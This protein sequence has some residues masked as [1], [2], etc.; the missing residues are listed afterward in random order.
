MAQRRFLDLPNIEI[1]QIVLRKICLQDAEDLFECLSDPVLTERMMH[2]RVETLHAMR[3]R[4]CGYL[5]EYERHTNVRFGAVL[6]EKHKMIGSVM[7]MPIQT[8]EK[9]SMGF[10]IHRAYWGHGYA[11]DMVRAA[12][13]FAFAKAGFTEI[14]A[15]CFVE[16]IASARVMERCGMRDC[17]MAC[18]YY[19]I[20]GVQRKVKQYYICK[21]DWREAYGKTNAT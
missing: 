11:T 12:I 6:R 15:R 9:A 19:F 17:G 13:D 7:L 14:E 5:R 2:C 20:Q 1:G 10:Y 8:H 4:I 16:N 21:E 3:Q 18:G